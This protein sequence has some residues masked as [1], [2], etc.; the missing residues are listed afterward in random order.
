MRSIVYV[1]TSS[2]DSEA[3][4]CRARSLAQAAGAAFTVCSGRGSSP[5]TVPGALPPHAALVVK[6]AD[7]VERPARRWR[8]RPWEARGGP[9]RPGSRDSNDRALLRALPVST[10]LLPAEA[11]PRARVIL[12]AVRLGED[13]P[14]ETDLAVV[15]QASALARCE[16][17][18]LHVAHAW[19]LLGES[20]LACPERGLG[21]DG[22][23]RVV[24]SVREQRRSRLEALLAAAWVG[25]DAVRT[26]EKGAPY[27]VIRD[28]ARRIR[29]DVLVVGYRATS[30]LW[31]VLQG[32]LAEA[33]LGTPGL[34]LLAVR[35]G[36]PSLVEGI[37]PQRSRA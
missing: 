7:P 3:A 31:G 26:I 22:V 23:R 30:G 12:A 27:P 17:A 11:P 34:A 29:A 20:I 5:R 15:R 16:G 35:A 36:A 4:V 28:V 37:A 33:F 24:A 8:S 21:P 25:D 18:R 9:G 14:D 19:Y 32:N 10:W 13:T 2:T 1:P 6:V